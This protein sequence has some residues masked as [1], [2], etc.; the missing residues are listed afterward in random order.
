MHWAS[1]THYPK[2]YE[3]TGLET[4]TV[5]LKTITRLP[6]MP[7]KLSNIQLLT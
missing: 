3:C 6:G 7:F 1:D 2:G 5:Y 4:K